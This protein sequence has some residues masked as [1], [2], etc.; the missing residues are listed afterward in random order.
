[1]ARF[2]KGMII[3]QFFWD[4]LETQSFRPQTSD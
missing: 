2:L 1:M 3:S 4:T